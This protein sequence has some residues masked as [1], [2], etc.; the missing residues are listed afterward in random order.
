MSSTLIIVGITCLVSILAFGNPKYIEG[1]LFWPPA[2]REK[3]E[4][5]RLLTYGLVHA[6]FTQR[7]PRPR[8]Q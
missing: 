7:C 8:R 5:Q 4:Y 6:N 1:M 3:G 2:I